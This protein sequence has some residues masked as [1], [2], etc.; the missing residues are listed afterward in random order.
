[1]RRTASLALLSLASTLLVVSTGSSP[2]SAAT[3]AQPRGRL[4]STALGYARIGVRRGGEWLLRDSLAG[5][6]ADRYGDGP[7]G[8]VPVAGDTNGDGTGTVSLFKDGLWLISDSRGGAPRTFRFGM[9]GDLPVLGDWNGDGVAT[10]GVFRKGR[11]FVRD[12]NG[13]GPARSFGFGQPGDVPVTGDWTGS[14][15]TGIGVVRGRQWYQRDTADGGLSNRSFAFGLA[16]DVPVTGD[17]HHDGTDEPGVFRGGTWYFHD[18]NGPGGNQSVRFGVPGDRPVVRRTPGLSPGVTHQVLKDGTGPFVTHIATLDPTGPA[19]VDPVLAGSA[20]PALA[21]TSTLAAQNGA[22]L[23]VN[24]DY[25]LD[26]GRPVH[27]F[28]SDATLVQTEQVHGRAVGFDVNGHYAGMGFPATQV[29]VTPAGAA[30]STA[31]ATWN[32]GGPSGDAIAG[33]TPAGGSLEPPPT[34]ACYAGLNLTGGRVVHPGGGVD[35]TLQ[36]TGTRCGGNAPAIP[37]GGVVL[38]ANQLSAGET[39]LR[40]LTPGQQVTMTTHPGFPSAVD[41][42]GGNPLLVSGGAVPAADVD[43]S[44]PYFG[45]NPRTIV[46]VRG[47]GK[48]LL[49]VV[50]G[51]HPGYSVGMTLREAADL[52]VSLGATD[53]INLDGGGSSTMWL[54]GIVANRPSDDTERPVS[55]ALVVLAGSDPSLSGVTVGP[56][57]PPP[58]PSPSPSATPSAVPTASPTAVPSA[59]PTARAALLRAPA[60]SPAAG[61][62]FPR[63]PFATDPG[64]TG[65]LADALRRSGTPL[66]PELARAAT[67]FETGR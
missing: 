24:G 9:P 5:G 36:V 58:T 6:T 14:G 27:A 49:V 42:I 40:S 46:G 63:G 48:I 16:G 12:T 39:F 35:Q 44:G 43:G 47:D 38:A 15:H 67:L 54:D 22:V 21:P 23:A 37:A 56:P 62:A 55:S 19:T 17:W 53:A 2:A 30:T 8:A 4:T 65:G 32:A 7:S 61:P 31:V 60:T 13:P 51:R 20:L 11:W 33:F 25:A 52:M 26:S 29:E 34:D 66:P 64:S 18:S 1:M 45:R 59:S 10:V 50:D 57:A 28:A 3:R 41:V